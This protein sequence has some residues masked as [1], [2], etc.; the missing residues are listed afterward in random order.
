MMSLFLLVLYLCYTGIS[1]DYLS[2]PSSGVRIIDYHM[3]MTGG[4]NASL[5]FDIRNV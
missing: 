3:F 2:F 1:S 4:T 5:L